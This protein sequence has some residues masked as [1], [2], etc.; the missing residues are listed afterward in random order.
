MGSVLLRAGALL[1]EKTLLHG[2]G[3]WTLASFEARNV[4]ENLFYQPTETFWASGWTAGAGVERRL[5]SNW[6]IRAEYRFTSFGTVR[7]CDAFSWQLFPTQTI[8]AEQRQT[9]FTQSMQAGQIGFAYAFD[10]LK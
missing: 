6:S 9:Q 10:P 7:R 1:D 8:Q 3:R 2:I 5:G 4:T